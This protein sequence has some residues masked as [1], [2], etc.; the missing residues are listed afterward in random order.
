MSKTCSQQLKALPEWLS[1]KLGKVRPCSVALLRCNEGLPLPEPSTLRGL[2]ADRLQRGDGKPPV[3][4][5]EQ[6]SE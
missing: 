3:G 2:F 4:S 6:N 1:A 5:K